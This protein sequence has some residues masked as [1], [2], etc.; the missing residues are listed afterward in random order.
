MSTWRWVDRRALDLLHDESLAEH[1]GASG[2]RDEGLLESALARPLN[3]SAYG[4]PDVHELAAAYGVGVAKNRPFVD[5][6]KRAAFLAVGLFLV[7]NAWRLTAPQADATMTMLAVAAGQMNEAT[8]ARWLRQHGRP[9][10]TPHMLIFRQLFDAASSTYTYLLGDAAS[11]QALLIDPVFEHVRRDSALLRELGLTLTAT[12]DT[13]VHA[14]HVTGAWL[15]KQ[16]LGSRILGA[17]AGG[18]EG[19]DRALA[20]GDRIEFGTRHLQVRATPGHTDGCLSFVLDD[21][22]RA[23]T[24]DA[25]LIRG[26]GRT[27]FQQ[28]SPERLYHS[29]H[30]QLLSLPAHCL[31]YPAHDYKGIT[32]TSVEEERRFNPRFGRR[33]QRDR[34]RRLHEQPRPAAPE[35]DGDRGAGQPALRPARRLVSATRRTGLG[36]A[37]L[38][39]CRPVGN[40]SGHSRGGGG[41]RA[42]HRR[43]RA[44]RVRPQRARPHRRREVAADGAV[45]RAAGRDRSR[46]S[47]GHG[48][49][50]RRAL[51]AGGGDAGQG[52]HYRRGQP[53]RGPAAL[54]RRRLPGARAARIDGLGLN[55]PAA[56]SNARS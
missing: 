20:Q 47:G 15:L 29:V 14:D 42:D 16:R 17:A 31:L 30:Q 1:G 50:L 36:A 19:L 53:R 8:F 48:V 12:L 10:L 46:P 21:E 39:L 44:R 52:R 34:L 4:N 51:G 25:L 18:A 56:A 2:L 5:G 49:P 22:S 11:G 7:L 26:C 54:A 45:G 24:G 32:V 9:A 55:A 23:F 28:G 38:G 33:Q 37:D 13:H 27:D 6:N 40:R 3:L 43:A 41:P 35:A